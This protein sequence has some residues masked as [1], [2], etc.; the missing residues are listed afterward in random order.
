MER[1]QIVMIKVKKQRR[2]R[3]NI[4]NQ[5]H[6]AI[7]NQYT[8]IRV[9]ILSPKRITVEDVIFLIPGLQTVIFPMKLQLHMRR[10]LIKLAKKTE[11]RRRKQET[12]QN[13][14]TGKK[15]KMRQIRV[16]IVLSIEW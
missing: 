10:R 12:A 13:S 5:I 2:R 1:N 6:G 9:L 8:S 16:L 15:K 3:R 14:D 11:G 7:A 4:L